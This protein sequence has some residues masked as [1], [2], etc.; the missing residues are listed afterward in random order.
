MLDIKGLR[1]PKGEGV[2]ALPPYLLE[3]NVNYD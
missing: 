3:N 2:K 1:D